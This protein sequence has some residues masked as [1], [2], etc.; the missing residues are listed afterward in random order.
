LGIPEKVQ[1]A[2][3]TDV[4]PDSPAAEAGLKQGDVILEINKEAVKN[5]E[6]AVRLTERPKDKTTLLKVWSK[7]NTRFVVVDETKQG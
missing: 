3:V 7:G 1:G 2:L 6:E 5:S 4:E